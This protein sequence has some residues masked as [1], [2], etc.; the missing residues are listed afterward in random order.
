MTT[1]IQNTYCTYERH[2]SNNEY[3]ELITNEDILVYLT[4]IHVGV[5]YD[6]MHSFVYNLYVLVK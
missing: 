4:G 2:I 6:I 5:I 3:S 1:W